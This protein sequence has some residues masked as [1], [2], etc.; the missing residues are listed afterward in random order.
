MQALQSSLVLIKG[1]GTR[2][3]VGRCCGVDAVLGVPLKHLAA[4]QGLGGPVRAL[5][6]VTKTYA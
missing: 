2:T 3:G 1:M 6:G 5:P 4:D